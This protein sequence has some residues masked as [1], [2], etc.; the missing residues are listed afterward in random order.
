MAAHVGHAAAAAEAFLDE[1]RD[2]P[3]A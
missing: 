2:S 3:R 1:I